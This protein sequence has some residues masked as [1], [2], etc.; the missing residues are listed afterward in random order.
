MSTAKRK[1]TRETEPND[2]SR[3]RQLSDLTY[4]TAAIDK[5]VEQY[6]SAPEHGNEPST[7]NLHC[8][9][10]SYEET[11]LREPLGT[12]RACG[13]DLECEGKHLQGT[14]GFVLREFFYPGQPPKDARTLCLLCRRYEVS[15]AYYL[16]ETGNTAAQHSLRITDHYN[17]VG[18]PGEY[19]VR[20]CIVSGTKYTGLPLPVVLH[21]RSAYTC[22]TKDGVKHLS[23]SRMRC[24]G[25]GGDDNIPNTAGPFLTRR[26]ALAQV[27]RSAMCLPEKSS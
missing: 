5:L 3:L 9:P 13:R 4:D 2:S 20:D 15:R 7:N 23:Q 6:T 16:Y 26:A 19:D 8:C 24:P 22:H 14:T 21:A 10:R 1:R 17:L 12:E 18:I 27:A 25:T 11:F